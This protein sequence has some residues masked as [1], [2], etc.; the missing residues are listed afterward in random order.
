M[1][2][3]RA[4]QAD[5]LDRLDPL[6]RL[7]ASATAALAVVAG[8]FALQLVGVIEKFPHQDSSTGVSWNP[9]LGVDGP[10]G[11][12]TAFWGAVCAVTACLVLATLWRARLNARLLGL[13]DEHGLLWFVVSWGIPIVNLFVPYAMTAEV[14]DHATD[15]S[16]R[17]LLHLWWAAWVLHTVQVW[18]SHTRADG[19][20]VL[21]PPFRIYSAA[22]GLAFAVLTIVVLRTISS[23]QAAQ[24]DRASAATTGSATTPP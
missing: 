9:T 1:A 13:R 23:A 12:L 2:A 17:R 14:W 21:D 18:S 8:V 15:R 10:S 19:V 20:R 24:A 5:R 16:S 11:W 7:I 6:G 3:G 4:E 22:T